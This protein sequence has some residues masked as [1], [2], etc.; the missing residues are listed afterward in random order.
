MGDSESECPSADDE[1]GSTFLSTLKTTP[2]PVHVTP[3]ILPDV[4][5]TPVDQTVTPETS[6]KKDKQNAPCCKR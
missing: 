1:F 3:P 2:K 5:M 6:Q 4:E